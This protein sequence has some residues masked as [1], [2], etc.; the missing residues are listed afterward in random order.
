MNDEDSQKKL[1][2]IYIEATNLTLPTQVK[3]KNMRIKTLS[4]RD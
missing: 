3:Q 2:Q 4:T 1:K